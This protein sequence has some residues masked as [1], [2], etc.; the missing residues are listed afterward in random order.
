M[1]IKIYDY[2]IFIYADIQTTL[3][4]RLCLNSIGAHREVG[5]LLSLLNSDAASLG[6][7]E[8]SSDGTGLLL[9]KIHGLCTT[10]GSIVS[11]ELA[12]GVLVHH[13]QHTGNILAH[14]TDSGNT[15]S[16]AGVLLNTQIG[17][18]FLKLLQL[19]SELALA[20]VSQFMC[21]DFSYKNREDERTKTSERMPLVIHLTR[22]MKI[23]AAQYRGKHKI[24]SYKQ[25]Q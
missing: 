11:S 21:S 13:S 10:L 23:K 16:L 25:D 20:L 5:I 9:S 1:C 7:G 18:I 15:G 19:L 22:K 8:L 14:G 24:A 2:A 12:L 4:K 6:R 3:L 17:E